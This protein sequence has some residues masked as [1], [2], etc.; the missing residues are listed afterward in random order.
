MTYQ[1]LLT[2]YGGCT[3]AG[4]ALGYRKQTVNKWKDAGIPD[5]EQLVIQKKNPRL[6]ADRRIVKKYRDLLAA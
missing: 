1:D 6:K 4:L 3:A 5:L 2:E